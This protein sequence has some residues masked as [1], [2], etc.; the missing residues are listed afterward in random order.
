MTFTN[1][2]VY[3][4]SH[5]HVMIR[6]QS[7]SRVQTSTYIYQSNFIQ[8][9]LNLTFGGIPFHCVSVQTTTLAF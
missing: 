8:L 4:Q 2:L 5:L 3:E 6:L 9:L 1:V 7:V